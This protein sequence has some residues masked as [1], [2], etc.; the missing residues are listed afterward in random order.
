MHIKPHNRYLLVTPI[1]EE[2]QEDSI[3]IILPTDYKK[4]TNP[5]VMC[6][7]KDISERSIFYNEILNGDTIIVERRMLNKI[8]FNEKISYL[9]LENYIYGSIN[10]ETN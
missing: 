6:R 9:V 4:P 8:E 10:N 1:E 3:S 7:V 2:K 5:Y